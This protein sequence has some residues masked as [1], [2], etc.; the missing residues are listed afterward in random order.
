MFTSVRQLDVLDTAVS[1]TAHLSNIQSAF[2]PN[3]FTRQPVVELEPAT[4]PEKAE[5][6]LP[7]STAEDLRL[8]GDEHLEEEDPLGAHLRKVMKREKRKEKFRE[9]MRGVWA[10]LKTP[11]GVFAAIYMLLV[12]VWGAGLV[13]LLIIPM[14]S[15]IKKLWVGKFSLSSWASRR[16]A[17]PCPACAEIAS[18]ILTGKWSALHSGLYDDSSLS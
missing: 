7:G 14:N 13:F 15:Y 2:W 4:P 1:T 11:L 18:Q 3:A 5:P 10:F 16:R 12:V 9:T 17:E 6:A 8:L